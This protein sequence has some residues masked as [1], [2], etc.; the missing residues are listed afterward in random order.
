VQ[1]DPGL[2]GAVV[3]FDLPTFSD[4]CGVAGLVTTGWSPGD[5]FPVGTT[6][7]VYTAYDAA[8]ND[9]SNCIFSV[10]VEDKEPPTLECV[11]SYEVALKADGTL[12]LLEGISQQATYLQTQLFTTFEDNCA[13]D[14][15][16]VGNNHPANL[17]F[18]CDDLG[19]NF[20]QFS[21]RD[22]YGNTSYCTVKIIVSDPL[23][24]CNQPPV[25]VCQ[26]IT[27]SADANCEAF[28]TAA[29]INNG[30][31]DPD[32]DPLSFS[33]DNY[34]PFG[35]GS[36]TV[37]LTVSD[38]LL[39][40]KCTATVTVKDATPPVITCPE[41]IVVSNDLGV[42]GAVVT[43]ADA[44][45][46][47]NCGAGTVSITET[48]VYSGAI[49]NWTVPA[50]VTS[51]VITAKGAE[52]GAPPIEG[53]YIVPG[54]GASMTGTFAVTPG[55]QYKILAGGHPTNW[56]NGGGGSFV[57]D[58][59][60]NP[61]II[62]G[63]GGGGTVLGGGDGPTKDG[64]IGTSGAAA[65]NTTCAAPGG[66]TGN[67]GGASGCSSEY[68]GG[69]GGLLTN[70]S[71]GNFAGSGGKAYVNGGA[72]GQRLSFPQAGFGGGGWGSGGVAGGGGGGY[73]GGGAAY[74]Y[75]LTGAVGGGGGSYNSG[76]NQ[77]NV[78][79]ANTGN[80][81]VTITYMG[82]GAIEPVQTE[83]L[84]S[85][86]TFPIGTTTVT[87]E[88]TDGAGNKDS[89]SFTITV[90][91]N[92]PPT[93]SC[94]GDQT[95]STDVGECYYTV[96]GT[97][98]D[99]TSYGDN[100][101]GSTLS[102]DYNNGSSLAGATFPFGKTT[103]TWTVEDAS[104][105]KASCSM[106]VFVNKIQTVTSVKVTPNTQQYSDL[107]TF[108]ATVTPYNCTG[109][110]DISGKVV[111]KVGTQIMGEA[112]IV[113]GVATLA[114]VPLLEPTPFGTAPTG[115]MAPGNH[116]VTAEFMNTDSDYLVTDPTT[117][118]M[119]TQENASV[120][121][122][123]Q[124]LQ[125]TPSA[126]SSMATVVLSANILDKNDSYRGDIRNATVTFVN[127]DTNTP[128]SP[129][130]PVS[131][132]VIPGDMTLGTVSYNWNVDIGNFAAES[133]TVGIVVGNYYIS[134]NSDDDTII[135]VYKPVGD[136]VTG[137][138]TI[139]PQ[140]SAGVYASTPGKRVNFGYNVG[141]TKKGNKLKGHLNIIF[142]RLEGDGIMH[143]YQA[144]SNAIQSLG[145][146]VA[147]ASAKVA[148]FITK[149]N[150]TDITDPLN[151]ISLGGNLTL[152]V[153][154]T[155]KGEPG[156]YDMIGFNLSDGGTLLYSSNWTGTKTTQIQLASGN[157]LIHGG[158]NVGTTREADPAVTSSPS[159][160]GTEGF[161]LL[162][163]PNPS[164]EDF[165]LRVNSQNRT[166]QIEIRVFD[167]NGR[168]VHQ[169]KGSANKEY[170]LGA[171]FEAGLYYISVT[172]GDKSDQVRM[173]KF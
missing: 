69:G 38:G 65:G 58:M 61:L 155:D 166:D 11:G 4:N 77:S 40:D 105:N 111:F 72:G 67:G 161:E 25:A 56:N 30:S 146:N 94:V 121:Y 85:G 123:G 119:I 75:Q 132:L 113:D 143:V 13:V 43:F 134:D 106:L 153:D 164:R 93:I 88:A 137:G 165:N 163:W 68:V 41:N 3:N 35:L 173:I 12:D 98:F 73:S 126:S 102:N 82:I 160:Y 99:P 97:E 24:A 6:I 159:V 46:I 48:F 116:T 109:A 21:A 91:D 84:A 120:D 2:C 36:N 9:S 27:L 16:F 18:D 54:K 86:S 135:T 144:K 53:E 122:T 148:T 81:V 89:C 158:Y 33:L 92:E 172:Q 59:S 145:V 71:D 5:V 167:V 131:T 34:G 29:Q 103:V 1:S 170:R 141:Y 136:F 57:T 110:G 80:G 45:A 8:Y 51:I 62:A 154:M 55:T 108:E 140:S 101:P 168:L 22:V 83:G 96:S 107:V 133:F 150:L 112:N 31:S 114:N 47:D 20:V 63:G 127:R 117:N 162:T 147:N 15:G 125:A 23:S 76:A 28:I 26:N 90:L 87:Y 19:D 118:L 42:C 139:V 78:G 37:E 64:Q 169:Q 60:N 7:V 50:G 70:G 151:V 17:K 128:I 66:S 52:G 156:T 124:T 152:K 100:C 14:L 138:G 130:I 115:Q 104:G 142:R 32:G 171:N 79:G 10:T 129:A 49:E 39:V 74:F 95:K 157:V 149:C 44:T